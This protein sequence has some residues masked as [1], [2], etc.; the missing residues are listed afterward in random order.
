MHSA[1]QEPAV[2]WE[3]WMITMKRSPGGWK[4]QYW[5][6]FGEVVSHEGAGAKPELKA[7]SFKV[8]WGRGAA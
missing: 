8:S 3:T 6:S 4:V 7:A 1:L 5:G 2:S